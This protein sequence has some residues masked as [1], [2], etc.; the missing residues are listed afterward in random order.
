MDRTDCNGPDAD[1]VLKYVKANSSLDGEDIPMNFSKF[2]VNPI[3]N[4]VKYY[5]PLVNPMDI[6]PDI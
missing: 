4:E 1:I 2:L 5:D 6:M 3:T